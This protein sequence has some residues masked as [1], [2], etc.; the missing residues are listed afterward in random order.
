[1]EQRGYESLSWHTVEQKW[2]FRS[3]SLHSVPI[4]MPL[5]HLQAAQKGG[6]DGR[7]ESNRG[8]EKSYRNGRRGGN[9]SAV[10]TGRRDERGI[11]N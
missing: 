10:N 11:L 8:G 3:L 7:R 5:C 1:M 6:E 4:C 9:Y 2:V